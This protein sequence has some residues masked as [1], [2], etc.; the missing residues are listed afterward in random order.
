MMR[1]ALL[2][3]PM[4]CAQA[5]PQA[6]GMECGQPIQGS[7][8]LQATSTVVKVT[9][10]S[11]K[12]EQG[13]D[14]CVLAP[15]W[16]NGSEAESQTKLQTY[17]D[18]LGAHCMDGL[19]NLMNEDSD[20]GL[21]CATFIDMEPAGCDMPEPVRFGI[22]FKEF[23]PSTCN[24]NNCQNGG[25][26]GAGAGEAGEDEEPA[27]GAPGLPG[28]AGATGP[29]G[30]AGAVGEVGPQGLAGLAGSTGP[31]GPAGASGTP[32]LAGAGGP[33]GPAGP[34]GAAGP[35]GPIGAAGSGSGGAAVAHPLDESSQSR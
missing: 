13:V 31:P 29:Q 15:D 8:L 22:M 20:E 35:P 6:E 12:K 33:A 11:I 2:V 26:A 18:C 9:D 30:L 16:E 10:H 3:S 25:A 23:C 17:V 1:F 19:T 7:A 24:T 14:E 27:A 21:T 34:S 4:C 5:V 32:G 28:L